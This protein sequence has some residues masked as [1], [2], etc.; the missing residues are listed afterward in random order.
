VLINSI[1]VLAI[2]NIGYT[3]CKMSFGGVHHNYQ[4][5][6]IRG[7]LPS[8]P[9]QVCN[10]T[11]TMMMN[12]EEEGT[13]LAMH[14]LQKMCKH[15]LVHAAF[16]E[17]M[18]RVLDD[19]EARV[20]AC[21]QLAKKWFFLLSSKECNVECNIEQEQEC[22][23]EAEQ[24]KGHEQEHEEHEEEQAVRQDVLL[25]NEGMKPV[26]IFDTPMKIEMWG[27]VHHGRH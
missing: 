22:K 8:L 4:F 19:F 3:K 16:E 13:L 7:C 18:E 2:D 27:K 6:Q 17:Y 24:V 15:W 20:L 25:D 26:A 14:Q 9:Q 5:L 23:Q 21:H 1:F 11:F 12:M 10:Y